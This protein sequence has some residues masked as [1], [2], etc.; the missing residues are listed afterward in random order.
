MQIYISLVMNSQN[1]DLRNTPNTPS[2]NKSKTPL[3]DFKTPPFGK[4]WIIQS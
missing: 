2:V 4:H 3:E 1:S